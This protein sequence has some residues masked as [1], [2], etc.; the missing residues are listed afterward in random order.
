MLLAF[1]YPTLHQMKR[2]GSLLKR[3]LFIFPTTSSRF[4]FLATYVNM[5]IR[6]FPTAAGGGGGGKSLGTARHLVQ[7]RLFVGLCSEG[8]ITC[9]RIIHF[10]GVRLFLHIRHRFLHTQHFPPQHLPKENVKN[11]AGSALK[12]PRSRK[13]HVPKQHSTV[14]SRAAVSSTFSAWFPCCSAVQWVRSES[15]VL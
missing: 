9:L 11:S 5:F 8:L 14:A 10:P 15:Y 7:V 4:G 3:S 1:F 12:W 6:F 13:W 2:A